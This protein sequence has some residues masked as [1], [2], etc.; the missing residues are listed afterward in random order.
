MSGNLEVVMEHKIVLSEYDARNILHMLND[1]I[2]RLESG[3]R[4]DN[5]IEVF[6]EDAI[7][8]E[9]LIDLIDAVD[10]NNPGYVASASPE[11]FHGDKLWF[12]EYT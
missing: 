3:T 12:R 8:Y 1:A 5:D 11:E 6:G 10:G 2:S 4:D 7:S 9:R